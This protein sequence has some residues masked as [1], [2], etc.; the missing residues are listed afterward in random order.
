M[1]LPSDIVTAVLIEDHDPQFKFKKYV[2]VYATGQKQFFIDSTA[3][4]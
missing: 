4:Q 1:T 2:H 3:F